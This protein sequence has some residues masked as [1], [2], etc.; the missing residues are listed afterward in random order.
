MAKNQE[1]RSYAMNQYIK[2]R[3]AMYQEAGAD[4]KYAGGLWD[5]AGVIADM[6]MTDDR[7]ELQAQIYYALEEI[8]ETFYKGKQS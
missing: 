6:P 2:N 3:L 4:E 8:L 1:K 7:E 5:W